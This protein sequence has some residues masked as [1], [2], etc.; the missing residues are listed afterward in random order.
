MHS[1]VLKRNIKLR[2]AVNIIVI[3]LSM[4]FCT[5]PLLAICIVFLRCLIFHLT[6]IWSK[7]TKYFAFIRNIDDRI[8]SI[9]NHRYLRF[10]NWQLA[11]LRSV[12]PSTLLTVGSWSEK[13]Q[14][15]VFAGSCNFLRFFYIRPSYFEV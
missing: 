7:S 14:N 10:L 13:S 1:N 15:S 9:F 8:C 5:Y 2:T 11:A 3:F 12:D 6:K 4:Y